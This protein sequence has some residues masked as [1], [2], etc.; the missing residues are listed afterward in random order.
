[1]SP[2]IQRAA[3][4]RARSTRRRAAS[5]RYVGPRR[6][7]LAQPFAL[8]VG[9]VYLLVGLVGF[10]VTGFSGLVISHGHSLL[11][12][13]LNVFHNL[14]HIVIGLG[15]VVVSRVPDSAITQGVLIGGGAV[16]LAAALLG[17]LDKLPILA[18]DGSLAPDNFLHL[19]SGAA[20]VVFGLLGAQQQSRAESAPV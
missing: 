8:I 13:D 10:T 19:F 11:G 20:A 7:N 4:G 14:V 12:F 15:F 5:E 1:M 17:F 9:G 18:V 16:Y 2:R 3:P 6:E